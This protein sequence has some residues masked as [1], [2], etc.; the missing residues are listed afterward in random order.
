MKIVKEV[1]YVRHNIEYENAKYLF[2][3]KMIGLRYDNINS[4]DPE[5]YRN[6]DAKYALARLQTFCDTGVI[7]AVHY[8]SDPVNLTIGIIK[9]NS[10]I[11]PIKPKKYFLKTVKITDTFPI[12]FF[13]YPVLAAIQPQRSTI[14]KWKGAKEIITA[15]Y[16]GKPLKKEVN[17]LAPA[18][19]EV[20]CYEYMV[21]KGILK[22]LLMPI[23][24]SLPHIDIYGISDKNKNIIAQVTFTN[25]SK[26]VLE[27]KE[28]LKKYIS[29]DNKLFFFGRKEMM[30]NDSKIKFI[31][32][33]TVFRFMN[34]QKET[35]LLIERML[36]K[37]V[38]KKV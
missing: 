27:K 2:D 34:K 29:R 18:Q 20:L 37:D 21:V 19:Q 1:I 15:I 26:K 10:K 13:D 7:V 25:D 16:N 8:I 12:S 22:H 30:F 17:S 11:I 35:K 23:G 5:D 9:P 3:N 24:R 31:S 33:E 28:I 38:N 4:I 14:S 36:N 32:L 6:K